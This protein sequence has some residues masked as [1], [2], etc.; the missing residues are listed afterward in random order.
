MPSPASPPHAELIAAMRGLRARGFVVGTVGNASVRT[1]EGLLVTPSRRD[2]DA[3]RPAD[4]VLVGP[5]GTV[6][7]G[8]ER[9]SRE[10]WLHLAVYAARPDVGAVVHTHSPHATAW[11]FLGEPLAPETEE[12]RYYRIGRVR[13]A[14]PAPAGSSDLAAGVP[15]ALGDA[16][17][18]LL[19]GHG[20][21]AVGKTI[22]QAVTVAE[23]VEHQAHVAWLLRGA[24]AAGPAQAATTGA[25]N[26]SPATWTPSR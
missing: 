21:V 26:G 3:M 4:L 1:D 19:H 12:V 20:V 22:A 14:P 11:S 10:L 5:D 13:V 25:A 15:G 9:P 23:A 18:V 8:D 7:A 17:A 2:Y 6:L 24:P 16:A